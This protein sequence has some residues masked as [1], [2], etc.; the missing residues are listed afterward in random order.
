MGEFNAMIIISK[1]T[2][3]VLNEGFY[4]NEFKDKNTYYIDQNI[5][6]TLNN[7]DINLYNH[8]MDSLQELGFKF[9]FAC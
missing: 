6:G 4:Q 5:I 3:N 2:K 7:N 9:K 8:A 1:I